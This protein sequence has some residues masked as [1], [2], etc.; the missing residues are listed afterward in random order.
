MKTGVFDKFSYNFIEGKAPLI[1]IVIL[2][3]SISFTLGFFAGKSLSVPKDNARAAEVLQKDGAPVD[4]AA[5]HEKLKQLLGGGQGG[6]RPSDGDAATTELQPPGEIRP[7]RA[8]ERA[9]EHTGEAEKPAPA[10]PKSEDK[11]AGPAIKDAV[12]DAPIKAAPPD[13][14]APDGKETA[15]KD[16]PAR[17]DEQKSRTAKVAPAKTAHKNTTA[18]TASKE[19]AAKKTPK[20]ERYFIQ[21]GAF[22][23]AGEADRLVGEL[24]G[25]GFNPEVSPDV[26]KKPNL[27]KVTLGG[28][29]SREEADR[30]LAKLAKNGIK[31]FVRRY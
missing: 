30:I 3:T 15:K 22:K 2:I 10:P 13:K 16:A 5:A 14:D 28:C 20:G 8:P 26:S 24:K 29:K 19:A 31:G 21:A 6:L 7:E 23:S 9:P 1:A 12:K 25:M 11:P 17:A 18:D 4:E 27:V